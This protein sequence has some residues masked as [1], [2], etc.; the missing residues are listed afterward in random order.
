MSYFSILVAN[1][2]YTSLYGLEAC[3]LTKTDLQS[4]DF[5]VNCVLMEVFKTGDVL[6]GNVRIPSTARWKARVR[7]YNRRN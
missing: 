6:S 3:S 7:L 1:A 5:T 2:A 4:L